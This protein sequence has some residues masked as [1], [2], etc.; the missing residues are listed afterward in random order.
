MIADSLGSAG[1]WPRALDVA[2]LAGGD[3]P[4]DYRM[5]PV[6]VD[7]IKL[8]VLSCSSNV[9]SANALGTPYGGDQLR[10][11]RTH[12]HSLWGSALNNESSN[13]HVVVRLHKAASANVAKN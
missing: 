1:A 10:T 13:H 9:G 3:N 4:A 12:N 6:I 8:P 2:D 5:L 7:A 11:D